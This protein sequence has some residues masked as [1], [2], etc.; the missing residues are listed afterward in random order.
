MNTAK[1]IIDY[2]IICEKRGEILDLGEFVELWIQ[3]NAIAEDAS[4]SAEQRSLDR[5]H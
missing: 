5:R 3:A 2:V 1:L 4:S